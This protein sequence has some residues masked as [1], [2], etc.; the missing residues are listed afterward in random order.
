MQ[1]IPYSASLY[2][3][4]FTG[5]SLTAVRP[6]PNFSVCGG[7]AF[8]WSIRF[9][10]A[11]LRGKL[12]LIGQEGTFTLG[13]EEGRLFYAAAGLGELKSDGAYCLKEN[14]WYTVFVT[15]DQSKLSLYLNG[16]QVGSKTAT[17]APKIGNAD[18]Q[19]G[20][21]LQG[22]I[23]YVRLYNYRLTPEQIKNEYTPGQLE[24]SKLELA[25]DFT[26]DTAR[27]LGKNH[28][29][30]ENKIADSTQT[31]LTVHENASFPMPATNTSK[32]FNIELHIYT[33]RPAF[34]DK[35]TICWNGLEGED[36]IE[37]YINYSAQ[38]DKVFF[39]ACMGSFMY[40]QKED[41]SYFSL[42]EEVKITFEY[43]NM[44]TLRVSGLTVNE[45]LICSSSEPSFNMQSMPFFLGNGHTKTAPY[46]GGILSVSIR[47]GTA[48]SLKLL[49]SYTFTSG[50]AIDTITGARLP[51][52]ENTALEP[53]LL[54]IADYVPQRIF[55]VSLQRL[56][57][58]HRFEDPQEDAASGSLPLHAVES[59]EW[60]EE[61][62]FQSPSHAVY[63]ADHTPLAPYIAAEL[64]CISQDHAERTIA[65]S[66]AS[67]QGCRILGNIQVQF[68]VSGSGTQTQKCYLEN[69]SIA[70]AAG[71][72]YLNPIEWSVSVSGETQSI[73]ATYHNIYI[74]PHTP[75][76]PW[77]IAEGS[78]YPSIGCIQLLSEAMRF[79][80]YD[81][82]KLPQPQSVETI[83]TYLVYWM[84]TSNLFIH[85]ETD[86]KY[87]SRK[88]GIFSF[89][90]DDFLPAVKNGST[91]KVKISSYDAAVLITLLTRVA[92]FQMNV[93]KV[94]YGANSTVHYAAT[95]ATSSENQ[96][97][98][99]PVY[100]GVLKDKDNRFSANLQFSKDTGKVV[101]SPSTS[102]YREMLFTPGERCTA[103]EL[104]Y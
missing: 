41:T 33:A 16:T 1:T 7:N 70:G 30:F 78:G 39:T 76:A 37:I 93:L 12:A 34:G 11:S 25:L 20:R 94:V 51:L 24:P 21:L 45:I 58:C 96:P 82:R 61:K 98:Y 69:H 99:I 62:S 40:E 31:V 54:T 80:A 38:E 91:Q 72:A 84:Q 43:V 79:Y 53:R 36:Q 3:Q 64:S 74:L 23:A 57:F 26:S 104:L 42:N 71:G 47:S 75:V 55:S 88:D 81:F 19:I 10:A 92:G 100:D 29:S 18:V 27:E 83:G 13:L 67:K 46:A 97:M 48:S 60:T 2:A 95:S 35:A 77:S 59:L 6:A 86:P 63:I 50:E 15:Y 103:E 9:C 44:G 66:G 68:T 90:W 4:R 14:T 5:E 73:G 32:R 65:L 85:D 102:Y 8:S 52:P 87:A 56:R 101:G 28:L 22:F 49:A 17:A 89:K